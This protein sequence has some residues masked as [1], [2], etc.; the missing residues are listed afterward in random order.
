MVFDEHSGPVIANGDRPVIISCVLRIAC[1]VIPT[2][3]QE[4]P[5]EIALCWCFLSLANGECDLHR[6]VFYGFNLE[7][8]AR[9]FVW[10]KSQVDQFDPIAG[11]ER[12]AAVIRTKVFERDVDGL[13]DGKGTFD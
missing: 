3:Q 4:W 12:V 10:Y 7:L 9:S 2:T 11:L 6:R 8:W 13:A 1:F 5:V